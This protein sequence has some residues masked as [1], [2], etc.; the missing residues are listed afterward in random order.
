MALTDFRQLRQEVQ[1]ADVILVEGISRLSGVIQAV[2]LSAWTH[3][4]LYVG[5]LEELPDNDLRERLAREEGWAPDQQ[6]L[7][8][9]EMG[10][11]TVICPL[12]RYKKYHLRICR[13]EGLLAED[14]DKVIQFGLDRLGTPYD[15]RQIFDLLRFFMPYSLLPRRWRSSLFEAAHGEMTRTVCSTLIGEAFAS[16]RYPILPHIQCDEAGKP[17]FQ[18]RNS[19]LFTPRDFDH[20]PYFE[21]I[22]YPFLGDEDIKLYR[23]LPWDEMGPREED[24]K[25]LDSAA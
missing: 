2:T 14:V 25:R 10:R 24:A 18:Q 20:S 23:D 16:V 6:L 5:R 17:H 13:P 19:K 22:K 4:A 1:P 8:E 9:A 21:V 12:D 15:V 3:A 11:G 7:L